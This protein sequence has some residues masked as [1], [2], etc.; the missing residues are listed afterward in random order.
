MVGAR[1]ET[2]HADKFAIVVAGSRNDGPET[3]FATSQQ[4]QGSQPSDTV[5]KIRQI[6]SRITM[7]PEHRIG[8]SEMPR[9]WWS[10]AVSFVLKNYIRAELI[11]LGRLAS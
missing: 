9:L 1:L 6:V 11:E 4:R 3:Q 10:S 2:L 8:D 7:A 5:R